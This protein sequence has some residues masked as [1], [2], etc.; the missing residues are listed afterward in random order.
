MKK[1]LLL[2]ALVCLLGNRALAQNGF[3][4]TKTIDFTGLPAP[5]GNNQSPNASIHWSDNGSGTTIQSITYDNGTRT[6]A[7][8]P[9]SVGNRNNNWYLWKGSHG[10]TYLQKGN[11]ANDYF[12]IDNLKAG[13]VVTVWGDPG[14]GNGFIVASNN[15]DCYNQTLSLEW[16]IEKAGQIITMNGDGPLQLQFTGQYSGVEKITI[17]S[18]T[19]HFDYDPGYEEYD[20]YDEFSENDP[21]KCRL[22]E[23][24]GKP[25]TY[26]TLSNENT[27]INYGN[28]TAQYIIL[29]KSKITANNRIAIDP[30]AGTW[31]FNY[32][33]RAPDEGKWANFSICNLK[34]GDRVVFSY[35]GTAPKFSSNGENGSY[36]G[37][38]AFADKYNDGVFDEGEDIYITSGANPQPDWSRGEGA[39]GRED[40]DCNNADVTL[41]YTKSYVITEDGHLDLAIAPDTRIVKI[42]IYSD[43][44]AMMVDK[45]G[46]QEFSNMSYFNITGELQANEHIVPGGLEVHVGSNDASQHAHVVSSLEGPVSIVNGVDGFKLPG[47]SGSIDDLQFEFDLANKIPETGTFYKFMPL[48]DGKMTVRFQAASMNYYRYDLRGDAVYYGDVSNFGDNNWAEVND[49][50]NEQTV[51]V[52]CPYYVKV[53]TDD[54]YED[55]EEITWDGV[56]SGTGGSSEPTELDLWTNV[57][58]GRLSLSDIENAGGADDDIITFYL[59]VNGGDSQDGWGMGGLT[60]SNG[61]HDPR[62]NNGIEFIRQGNSWTQTY[63][64]AQ[65][66][67]LANN[68]GGI[69]VTLW[70]NAVLPRVTLTT[71]GGTSSTKELDNGE[72]I[73]FEIDVKAGK[74]YYLYGGWNASSSDLEFNGSGQGNNTLEYFPY[75][76]GNNGGTMK[77][78]GVAKLLWV[79]Y[80]P[81]NNIAPLAKWVPNNTPGVY[82]DE[83]GEYGVPNPDEPSYDSDKLEYELAD[84]K[85]YIGAAV[86]VKKMSGN[87]TGCTPFIWRAKPD[88]SEGK[89]MIKGI[90]FAE[91]KDKG[92]TIL[93]KIGNPSVRSNPVYTLTIAY[94]ADPQFDGNE[95]RGA[96]GYSWDY[97]SNSLH[98]LKWASPH[99]PNGAETVDYGHYFTNYHEADISGYT[100]KDEVL[101]SSDQYLKPSES[102]LLYE[103]IHEEMTNGANAD[104]AF[105]YNLQNAGNLYDP[106]F[107]NKY[108]MEGDNADVIWETEGTV[109]KASANSSVM[110][111]E[112]TGGNI[113]A[114]E[115]D[116]DRYVGILQGSEFRIPWLMPND[117]V[118]IW[119]GTGKGAFNDQ[120]VFNIRGAYDAVHNEI[121]PEDEYIVGGSHWNV[122]KNEEG[123]VVTNDPYYRG[124]YHFFATGDKNNEGKPADMVFTMT[125]GT[126]CKIYKIQIYRGDRIITNEIKGATENDKFLLWSRDNDPNDG[127]GKD[128]G[129]TYN[130]TLNY[131]GKDQKL[132]DGTNGVN[133]DFAAKTG[134][135]NYELVTSSETDPTKPTYNTFSYPNDYGQIG[136]FRARGKDMEKNMKYVADYGEHNVTVAYQ[137]TMEYPYTWDFMDMTGWGNNVQNFSLE[138]AYGSSSSPTYTMPEWFDNSDQWNASYENSSTDLSLWDEDAEN[139]TYYL[140]LNSQSG[141]T[142]SNLKEK[143]NIFETAKSI[144]GNQVWANGAVVPETQGLWFY[145][146]NNNSNNGTWGVTNDGLAFNGLSTTIQKVVV[147]NVPAGA[148]VY[149]RMVTDRDAYDHAFEFKGGNLDY[150]VYGPELV[151]GTTD[152]YIL[153]IKNEGA[154]RHLT[155]S[156]AGYQLKKLAVS[157]D[158]KTVNIKGY[159]TESRDHDIDTR[160]TSYLTG[161]DIKTYLVGSPDYANRTLTLAEVSQPENTGYKN[162]VLPGKKAVVEGE[163]VKPAEGTGCVL[164]NSTEVKETKDG[165][166]I[167]TKEAKILNGGFHLF[168]PDMHDRDNKVSAANLS[169]NML[170]A[171]LDATSI[172]ATETVDGTEYTNYILTYKYYKLDKDGN[173]I[174]GTLNTDGPEIF[175][176]VA[177]G[178][179]TGKTNTAYLPLPTENVD[180]SYATNPNNHAKFTFVFADELFEQNQGIATAVENVEVQQ[181]I[182]GTAEWY[183]LNGQKLNGKPS[184]GG[185]YIINGKKVLVK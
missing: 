175:Y 22:E 99:N 127:T 102:G 184:K 78:C 16:D 70:N 173:K 133:N 143:D 13:D 92:G 181:I 46:S 32:G 144:D 113:H 73:E 164:Y 153:A 154:K 95:G 137:Q 68:S 158:P 126:M 3:Y 107:T 62:N 97:S 28:Q 81:D 118:I 42:K 49:R 1:Y 8:H 2:L 151:T 43:H 98:G 136:T 51:N 108:D 166:T 35:T 124:C 79:E 47:M 134:C 176:R 131:F 174:A 94:S 177:N 60:S 185:L 88:D 149:L 129:P 86:T 48:E 29:H 27:G 83:T 19:S 50:P 130:W 96:R 162:F 18:R 111:N 26:Y 139:E 179:A 169:N 69:W 10:I 52:P 11:A 76:N 12:Y 119:M 165:E 172:P 40:N 87:I 59:S 101:S 41:Q 77:A 75:G 44:R 160:L 38:K 150:K 115:K 120:A 82:K 161:K 163:T 140:R 171:N 138:D 152:E 147:P 182:N 64:V 39:I 178:G 5:D 34:E 156:L 72:V 65:L 74:T 183:N 141:Q 57:N 89:L 122:V 7:E 24:N 157:K 117:R 116:P 37:A 104:W 67:D 4:V 55:V 105:S 45:P 20:M 63:T 15:N 142:S 145:T 106:M 128:I 85:G 125:G 90:K 155:L 180:P 56:S 135:I 17:K 31:R 66:K 21:K 148:A 146:L 23:N 100:S 36:N 54:G 30:N 132:A 170:K 114:S 25:Y 14:N 53:S 168:V 121:K 71:S 6:F 84:I 110:F 33:L 58:D 103:E 9:I 109:I 123:Q 93:I 80:S 112:F 167:T 61:S 91:G 159:A